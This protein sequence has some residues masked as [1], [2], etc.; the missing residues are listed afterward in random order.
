[1]VL[2]QCLKSLSHLEVFSYGLGLRVNFSK[3]KFFGI[4]VN[5]VEVERFASILRCQPSSL[6]CTYLGLP[7]GANMNNVKNWNPI[8]ENFQKNLTS[9]KSHT[10]FYGGRLTLIN[11]VL[12]S[13]G[14]YFFSI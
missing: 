6:P 13:L 5:N 3:S 2:K 4:G 1:M 11:S 12:G 8:I 10:L 7:I 14:I 9:L